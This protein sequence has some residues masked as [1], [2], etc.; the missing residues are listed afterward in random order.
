VAGVQVAVEIGIRYGQEELL[1][2]VGLGIKDAVLLP[3]ALPPGLDLPSAVF[4][5]QLLASES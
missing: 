2:G 3:R 4:F 5:L 1:S